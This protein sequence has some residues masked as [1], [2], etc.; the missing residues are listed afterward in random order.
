MADPVVIAQVQ[1]RDKLQSL[2]TR[3]GEEATD[4]GKSLL[5][6]HRR[7]DS[8]LAQRVR[9]ADAPARFRR[10]FFLSSILFLAVAVYLAFFVAPLHYPEWD[11][12]VVR[13]SG[14]LTYSGQRLLRFVSLP[15]MWQ[16][17][18]LSTYLYNPA[19]HVNNPW[20]VPEEEESVLPT[21]G[22]R[23]VKRSKQLPVGPGGDL[24]EDIN[25]VLD[26]EEE[27]GE[28]CSCLGIR[29]AGKIKNKVALKMKHITKDPGIPLILRSDNST[30]LAQTKA[31]TSELLK[32]LADHRDDFGKNI[33][34]AAMQGS[35]PEQSC[36]SKVSAA[37]DTVLGG[38]ATEAASDFFA[39]W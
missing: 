35:N 30:G 4:R 26:D 21:K 8:R 2:R 1:L 37:L 34:H 24:E 23:G 27:A 12:F 33:C 19:C 17:P 36:P 15:F 20:Y 28:A 18:R 10:R 29:G 39:S 11:S 22:K 13:N 14:G 9:D 5:Q 38:K 6:A 31:L 3:V 16:F 25:A 32:V 7:V